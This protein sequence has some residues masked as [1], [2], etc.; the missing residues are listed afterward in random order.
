MCHQGVGVHDGHQL[1]QQVRL[2]YEELGRQPLHDALQLL[3]RVPGD[4]VPGFGLT[5]G[6]RLDKPSHR[7]TYANMHSVASSNHTFTKSTRNLNTSRLSGPHAQ[8][9]PCELTAQ[10]L[11]LGKPGEMGSDRPCTGVFPQHGG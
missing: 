1:V 9:L 2:G 7:K 11:T 3:G 4:A 10:G 6:N 5:P 8:A